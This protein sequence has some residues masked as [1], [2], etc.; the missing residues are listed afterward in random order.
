MSNAA[1]A[2]PLVSFKFRSVRAV[3]G[4]VAV[5]ITAFLPLGIT[6]EINVN[7]SAADA[8]LLVERA[9]LALRELEALRAR[10]TP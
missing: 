10:L 5:H 9:Q 7:L 3:N 2:R 8:T 1:P 6:K 4:L